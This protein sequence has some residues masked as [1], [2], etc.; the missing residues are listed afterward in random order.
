MY[1]IDKMILGYKERLKE[2]TEDIGQLQY[3]ITEKLKNK[4]NLEK[5]IERLERE[6]D[7]ICQQ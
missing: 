2:I 7:K 3:Q 1:E 5:F 4:Q 6:D